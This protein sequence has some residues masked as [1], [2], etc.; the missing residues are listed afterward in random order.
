MCCF[1]KSVVL[2]FDVCLSLNHSKHVRNHY[3]CWR[4]CNLI[5][6]RS[7]PKQ[8]LL[9]TN[10][11]TTTEKT[12]NKSMY[13]GNAICFRY[14]RLKKRIYLIWIFRIANAELL[15]D[16]IIIIWP[17]M[18]DC[19]HSVQQIHKLLFPQAD[20]G[21]YTCNANVIRKNARFQKWIETQTN[22]MALAK[23]GIRRCDL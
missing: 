13:S 22:G 10:K 14:G 2:E 4:H 11:A 15:H 5:P 17:W 3:K 23:W 7:T 9:H 6:L 20:H 19:H 12:P 21:D 8:N 16:L 1:L 18:H